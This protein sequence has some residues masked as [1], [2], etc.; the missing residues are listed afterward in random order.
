MGEATLKG[1]DEP[2]ALY[3]VRPGWRA[4]AAGRA[5]TDERRPD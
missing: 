1:F 2:V 5:L 3:K 4:G